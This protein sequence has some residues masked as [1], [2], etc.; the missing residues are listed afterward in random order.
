MTS[1]FKSDNTLPTTQQEQVS[2]FAGKKY[3]PV[4]QKVCAMPAELADEFQIVCN[5][6]GDPLEG[7]PSLLTDPP[8][9][10]PTGCYMAEQKEK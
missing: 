5:I 7:M 9:F 10:S 3:K 8:Q 6:M 1:Q 4:P 2:V